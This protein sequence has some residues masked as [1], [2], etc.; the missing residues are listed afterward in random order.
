MSPVYWRNIVTTYWREIPS[1]LG[2]KVNLGVAWQSSYGEKDMGIREFQ[3]SQ[4]SQGR[5]LEEREQY[6]K[7]IPKIYRGPP[8]VFSGWVHAGVETN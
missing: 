3:G 8:K 4:S 2:V 5:V 1:H 6:R 7:R